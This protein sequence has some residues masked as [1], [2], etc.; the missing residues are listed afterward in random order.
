M[1]KLILPTIAQAMHNFI[2][3]FVLIKINYFISNYA[4]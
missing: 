3:N 2:N 4:G 1:I